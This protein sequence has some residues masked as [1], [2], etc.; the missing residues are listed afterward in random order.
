MYAQR[1]T[2]AVAEAFAW[3]LHV[4]GRDREAL[5]YARRSLRGAAISGDAFYR[6]AVI[7][8]EAGRPELARSRLKAA[9]SQEWTIPVLA[10][11]AAH[12]LAAELATSRG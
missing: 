8:A 4:R 2:A 9:L 3:T 7:A 11:R 12:E 6:A 5:G 1:P 10:R